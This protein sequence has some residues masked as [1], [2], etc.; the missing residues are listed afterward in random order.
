MRRSRPQ[1]PLPPPQKTARTESD[2][3]EL[4][5]GNT[6]LH[7]RRFELDGKCVADQDRGGPQ[8]YL[9]YAAAGDI[10]QAELRRGPS[11]AIYGDITSVIHRG[12]GRA[13]ETPCPLYFKPGMRSWCGGCDMQHLQYDKQLEAKQEAL[14]SLFRAT[15][16][17]GKVPLEKIIR[18]PRI[19]RYRNKIQAPF[20]MSRGNIVAGFFRP[21]SHEIVDFADCPVQDKLSVDII[22]AIKKIAARERWSIYS[23]E[24]QAG[25]LRHVF[26]RTTVEGKALLA[27]IGRGE[28]RF[29]MQRIVKELTSKFPQIASVYLNIQDRATN[30]IM[31]PKWIKL[32]GDGA[33]EETIGSNKFLFYPG[34]FLQVNT[35]A[36]ELLY[37][38]AADFLSLGERTSEL[39][40]LYCGVGTIGI[41]VGRGFRFVTG[42]E[43]NQGA[44]ACAWKNAE[45][46]GA[47]NMRFIAGHAETVFSDKMAESLRK[48]ISVIVDPPRQ[49]CAASL[50]KRFHHPN[51]RKIVYISCNPV[52]FVRD[53]E[54]LCDN[55]F[56]LKKVQPLDL[57]PQTSHIELVAYFERKPEK[58]ETP[59]PRRERK[60]ER[61]RVPDEKPRRSF[62]R[63]PQARGAS[64]NNKKSKYF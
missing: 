58:E 54:I 56:E 5:L 15:R 14:V 26:I 8:V 59:S 18:S 43:E 25:W 16:L 1:R 4:V 45:R 6:R 63:R 3:P 41:S 13:Q 47:K 10:V 37:R 33:L 19:L 61:K 30:V 21:S 27:F 42:I 44:V 7:V 50:L 32:A 28:P 11:N 64:F 53:A 36:A 52:T 35:P 34:S 22:Q 29:N 31:G 2:R 57:F 48:T 23:E 46:N 24:A 51:V 40:D 20:S 55:G 49:G 39:Y 12:D 62:A 17:L 9:N 60:E 38:T